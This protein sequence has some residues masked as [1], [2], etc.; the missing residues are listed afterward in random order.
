MAFALSN[1]CKEE[2]KMKNDATYIRWFEEIK[3]EDVPLVGGK[4]ASLHPL[5]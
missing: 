4:N 2:M 5:C 3:I 1:N